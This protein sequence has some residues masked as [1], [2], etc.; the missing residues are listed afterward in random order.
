MDIPGGGKNE[1]G[2]ENCNGHVC[3]P[4]YRVTL[5]FHP[6]RLFSVSDG[7]N[8]NSSAAH[9]LPLTLTDSPLN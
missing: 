8:P 5:L 3:G 7:F 1:M 6:D 9:D 4:S 2:L